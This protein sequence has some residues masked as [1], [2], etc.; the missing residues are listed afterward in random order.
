MLKALEQVHSEGHIHRDVKPANFVMDPADAVDPAAGAPSARSVETRPAATSRW[1]HTPRTLGDLHSDVES[2]SGHTLGAMPACLL[3]S[4]PSRQLPG[5]G[6]WLP[7]RGAAVAG[8]P[9]T[10]RP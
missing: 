1:A 5:A 10:Q 8:T 6:L 2:F 3:S 9:R 4:S 7:G